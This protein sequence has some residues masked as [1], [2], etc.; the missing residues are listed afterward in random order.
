[1]AE[2]CF[3]RKALPGFDLSVAA[4]AGLIVAAQWLRLGPAW[5]LAILE[6]AA[7]TSTSPAGSRLELRLFGARADPPLAEAPA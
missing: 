5:N 1:M 6:P 4:P 3:Q 2:C 7:V